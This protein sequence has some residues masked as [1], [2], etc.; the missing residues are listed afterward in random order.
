MAT[1]NAISHLG[2]KPHFV[3]IESESL[4]LCPVALENRLNEVAELR[5]WINF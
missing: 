5:K 2:A 4:G 1:A 3:D